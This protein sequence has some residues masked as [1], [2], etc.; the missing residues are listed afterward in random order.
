MGIVDLNHFRQG[1]QEEV[2]RRYVDA[3]A[4]AETTGD[5]R[6]GIAAGHAWREWLTLFQS[7]D[8]NEADRQIDRVIAM[9][10]RG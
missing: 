8:Q 1:R 2:W 4:A 3:R 6:D 7:A 9:K 5:I 10:R